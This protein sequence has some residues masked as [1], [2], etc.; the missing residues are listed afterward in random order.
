MDIDYLLKIPLSNIELKAKLGK[1]CRIIA[2]M[3]NIE[4]ETG[5]QYD[6]WTDILTEL[7]IELNKKENLRPDKDPYNHFPPSWKCYFCHSKI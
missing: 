2:Y 6:K 5:E 1:N 3:N 4:T 7:R